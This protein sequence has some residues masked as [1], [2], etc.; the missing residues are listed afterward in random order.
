MTGSSFATLPRGAKTFKNGSLG[1]PNLTYP[2]HTRSDITSG[3]SMSESKSRQLN[4][5]RLRFSSTSDSCNEGS[6]D[7]ADER[8]LGCRPLR[9]L[10][11]SF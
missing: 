10:E 11:P 1:Y 8:A 9:G 4:K 2:I 7:E 3:T 6:N 5:E